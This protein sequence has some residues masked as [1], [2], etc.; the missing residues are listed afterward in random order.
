[1]FFVVVGSGA[2]TLVPWTLTYSVRKMQGKSEV[3]GVIYSTYFISVTITAYSH[4][5]NYST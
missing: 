2:E 5:N 3:R 1:M 4:Q